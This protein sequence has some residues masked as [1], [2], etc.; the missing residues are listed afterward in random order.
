M[1][2]SIRVLE[3]IKIQLILEYKYKKMILEDFNDTN[4]IYREAYRVLKIANNN[5]PTYF[6]K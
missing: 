4:F 5:P 1:T 2:S 6:E 3:Y